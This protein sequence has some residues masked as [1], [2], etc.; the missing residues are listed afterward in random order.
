LALEADGIREYVGGMRDA[1][2]TLL[3]DL[4]DLTDSQV[5]QPS[6]L[7][8][9]TVGHVLA[10]IARNADSVVRRLDGIRRSEI[11]DQYP[12]GAAGRAAE[13]EDGAVESAAALIEDVRTTCVAVDAACADI[14]DDAWGRLTRGVGGNE[15]PGYAV[16]FS[17]WREV[18]VHHV[19]LGL[20]YQPGLWP[21]R[22]V[23]LWMPEVLEK[24]PDRTDPKL[25]LAWA[26]GRGPAPE[27][28]SWG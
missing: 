25:L 12:G 17:R 3:A 18:E 22:L 7:P 27:L 21:D 4:G 15:S 6:L 14:P 1:H 28:A 13:I 23:E 9:W 20:G 11:V 2:A 16:I 19:D 5:R 10:H 26:L 8:D 24:L